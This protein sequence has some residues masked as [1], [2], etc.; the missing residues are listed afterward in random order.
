M[1]TSLPAL[2]T[3]LALLGLSASGP[4]ARGDDP[5]K[6]PID[7]RWLLKVTQG[8]QSEEVAVTI[9]D[10]ELRIPGVDTWWKNLRPVANSHSRYSAVRVSP[11]LVWGT[12]QDPVEFYLDADG[13][14]HHDD[15]QLAP[16]LRC[17]GKITLRRP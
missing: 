5:D 10:G 9:R 2:L 13:I 17:Q 14:L 3:V 1:P 4:P 11:G 6:L 7:G 15:T 8:A 12:R 16:L